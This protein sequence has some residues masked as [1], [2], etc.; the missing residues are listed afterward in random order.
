MFNRNNIILHSE[1]GQ[2]LL[3]VYG[4]AGYISARKDVEAFL[5]LTW[6]TDNL[7]ITAGQAKLQ[8]FTLDSQRCKPNYS[9]SC[10]SH[11]VRT[12]WNLE[13]SESDKSLFETV[14][15]GPSAALA[16]KPAF[17]SLAATSSA[18]C[19]GLARSDP[20][21][22]KQISTCPFTV[23]ITVWPRHCFINCTRSAVEALLLGTE[24][25]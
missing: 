11:F 14:E 8:G 1:R 21:I 16:L 4:Y 2:E 15:E 7:R 13:D 25:A 20:W 18:I 24:W 3:S 17:C 5:M 10:S 6:M 19:H 22:R 23:Y 12:I 9:S